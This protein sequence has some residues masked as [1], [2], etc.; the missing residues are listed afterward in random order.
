MKKSILVI[1]CL[2]QVLFACRSGSEN[3]EQN[4]ATE[5]RDTITHHEENES[6]T[7]A[8]VSLNNGEKWQANP[9]TSEGINNMKALVNAVTDQATIEN[10]HSLSSNMDTEFN[11]I[12]QKCTMT[13]ESHN[14]LHNYLIP[15]KGMIDHLN[16]ADIETCRKALDELKMHLSEYENY[17]S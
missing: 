2:T 4:T 16:S 6:E 17:F 1:V 5:N 11:Q 12:L 14:Q 3:K 15:M 7:A 13:G 10:Y 9:E 8:A